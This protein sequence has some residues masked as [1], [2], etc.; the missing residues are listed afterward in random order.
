MRNFSKPPKT[1]ELKLPRSFSETFVKDLE[2]SI[3]IDDHGFKAEYLLAEML[4]K[5]LDPKA[6]S[7]TIRRDRAIDKWRIQEQ[8]NRKT[9]FRIFDHEIVMQT[10]LG[11]TT[12]DVF[13]ARCRSLIARIL[14]PLQYPQVLMHLSHTNGAS[15]RVRRS[16]LSALHKLM[17]EAHVSDSA[18]KH[19]LAC[20]TGTSGLSEQC[21]VPTEASV[22]FTVDKNS[23]IDR[24][25]CKEP[26]VNMLM[27][28]SVGLEIRRRLK[29]V[30]IDLND[31]SIN[32][33]LAGVAVDSGL[34]TVDL[35][36]ASDSISIG[37]VQALLPEDWFQLLDDLRVKHT[38]VDGQIHTLEMFSSMGNG[39]TFELESLLFYA[40]TSVV[41]RSSGIRGRVSVYGDD[42][43]APCAVVPRLVRLF[44][45]L[46]FRT[47]KRKTFWRGRFRESCG[48]HFYGKY[49]VS[50]FYIK[51]TV[52]H[53]PD[54]INTLNKLAEWSSRDYGF[55]ADP[56]ILN[57]H[58][59]YAM[60]VPPY[61]WGGI[62][63]NDSSCLVTGHGPRFR[64]VAKTRSVGDRS[65]DPARLMHWYMV[66]E[67]SL[68]PLAVDPIVEFAPKARRCSRGW[69]TSWK[70]WL[71]QQESL[72]PY[73]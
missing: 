51:R 26:E 63:Y 23:D 59:K 46:G 25:A 56:K 12:F 19:W 18:I 34:A 48:M 28:R 71:L 10:D 43:I 20:A 36:S 73:A 3:S 47:N 39:F 61:L 53:I 44:H 42:I 32:Q 7:A 2:A 31:Q 21:L 16:S 66:R 22:L 35:S 37:L 13:L 41:C 24:V 11:W 14:G 64:L 72:G 6:T 52:S 55:I 15:T 68:Q 60:F 5:Y 62:D 9:N 40:I 57:F 30:G 27:Q 33:R 8:R 58:Q 38:L 1:V 50:P 17:G 49:D 69:T 45:L 54:L 29:R 70:P 67:N 65:F 4:S